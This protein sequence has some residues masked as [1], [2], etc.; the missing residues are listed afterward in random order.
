MIDRR[1]M[2]LSSLRAFE[3]AALNL[4]MGRAGA[5]LGVTQGAIS[6]QVRQLEERL[7]VALFSRAHNT[8]S[9]TP[10]GSRLLMS[11]SQGLDLIIDGARNLDPE[12]VSG[13]LIVGCTQSIA[14]SWA[15]QHICSFYE[16]Y[17]D[18]TITVREIESQQRD[19]PRDIDIAICYGAPNIDDRVITK[20]GAP[21]LYP[22]CSP[23]LLNAEKQRIHLNNMS[24]LTFIHDGQVSWQ[25]W[26]EK[27]G[28]ESSQMHSNIYFPNASQALRA[29]VLGAGV[30]LAN[31]LETQQFIKDGQLMRLLNKPI[32]EA[33]SYY[34]ISPSIK[35]N[36][37]KSTIFAEWIIN[38]CDS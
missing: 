16:K 19:I 14:A 7:G 29:A 37:I 28:V 5:E 30:A 36:T 23:A 20:I 27:H 9:L 34:L 11:V 15:A 21:V 24:Q 1:T 6:H 18:I 32:N 4:H 3:S 12:T 10:A 25:R 2:P 38:A 33:H 26:M 17:P 31:T 22:V 35:N 8:L 13:P